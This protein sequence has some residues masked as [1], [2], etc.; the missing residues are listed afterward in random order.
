M[1]GGERSEGRKLK[2]KWMVEFG[3]AFN[4][5]QKRPSKLII[6]ITMRLFLYFENKYINP[7]K[8]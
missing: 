1:R 6:T 4:E 3:K 2:E 5:G 7:V 8:K